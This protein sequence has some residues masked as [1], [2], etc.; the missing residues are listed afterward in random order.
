MARDEKL[1][2]RLQSGRGITFDELERLIRAFGFDLDRIRGSHRIYR[3][4][5]GGARL[6]VQPQGKDAKPYQIKQ[7]LEVVEEFGLRLGRNND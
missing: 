5:R 7:L 2:K 3:H 1:F 6:N 4:P